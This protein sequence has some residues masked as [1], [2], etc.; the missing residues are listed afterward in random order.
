MKYINEYYEPIEKIGDSIIE[1]AEMTR[2]QMG[3]LCGIINEKRPYKI[4]E[5]GVAAGS[6]TVVIIQCLEMIGQS[7]QLYSVDLCEKLYYN[8]EIDT[9]YITS[10]YIR[11]KLISCVDHNLLLGKYLPQ[12]LDVIGKELDLVILDTVHHLPGELLD[13][14]AVLPYLN[15]NAIVVLH[16]TSLEHINPRNDRYAFA[17]QVLFQ[18]VKAN[19]IL[20]NSVEYPNIAAFEISESTRKAIFD[21]FSALTLSWYYY[22]SERE[23][24]IYKEFYHRYYNDELCRIFDQA[25]SLNYQ[26]LHRMDYF[27][28][29]YINS[30][31]NS[32]FAQFDHILLYGVGFRGKT[33][34]RCLEE[35]IVNMHKVEFVVTST[36]EAEK[37][38]CLVW[39]DIPYSFK[40]TLII[41]SADSNEIRTKLKQSNWI[42]IDIPDAVWSNLE[43][44]YG[45]CRGEMYE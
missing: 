34:F 45:D 38:Q 22:P 30:M 25:I 18:S 17:T 13:F 16:D 1:K 29:S 44:V 9:G 5:V 35:N 23:L 43:T 20:N 14:L 12:Q 11:E 28:S 32:L 40:D 10:E 4:L 31:C 42:W 6:T 19:K 8:P 2:E 3:F 21:V 36:T 33:L 27:V 39:L 26:S 41:L 24:S 37:S 7:A 15:E